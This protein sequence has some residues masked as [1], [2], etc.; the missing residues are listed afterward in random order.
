YIDDFASY[1]LVEALRE[2]SDLR[3]RVVTETGSLSKIQ[4]ILNIYSGRVEARAIGESSNTVSG[5]KTLGV[6]MKVVVVDRK[7]VMV[8]SFNLTQTHLHVNFDVCFIFHDTG[9]IEKFVRIFDWLWSY[10]G[11]GQDV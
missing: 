9:T 3:I 2:N 10:A 11:R 4:R 5:F 1:P 8:G 6:H 7:A